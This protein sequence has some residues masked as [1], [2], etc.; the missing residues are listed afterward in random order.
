MLCISMQTK[1]CW[2]F[3][4]QEAAC[5]FWCLNLPL[6]ISYRQ[7][8]PTGVFPSVEEDLSVQGK[9]KKITGV[10]AALIAC[11]TRALH[12]PTRT[13]SSVLMRPKQE[14]CHWTS[15]GMQS[16]LQVDNRLFHVFVWSFSLDAEL[17]LQ[18]HQEVQTKLYLC[19]AFYKR[20][21]ENG[22]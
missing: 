16:R 7:S 14:R 15:S 4:E 20:C 19:S 3:Q 2:P 8:G 1:V 21:F 5:N 12:P 18:V 10:A 17:R 13:F 11:L 9:M 22:H 6:D